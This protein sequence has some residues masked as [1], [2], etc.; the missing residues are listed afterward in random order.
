MVQGPATLGGVYS[1]PMAMVRFLELLLLVARSP[2]KGGFDRF[3]LPIAG[4][5]QL[6]LP[7]GAVARLD[8][9]GVVNLFDFGPKSESYGKVEVSRAS[10]AMAQEATLTVTLD[11]SRDPLEYAALVAVPTTVA[12]KQTEDILSDYKG[13]LIYGQQAMGTQKMQLISVPFRGSRSLR[14]LLE[15]AF[16]GTSPGAVVIRHLENQGDRGALRIPEIEVK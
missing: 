10:L 3:G 5:A 13:Q 16:A 8:K 11:A 12:I 6:E 4:P 14:L 1:T 9:K 15:G 7:E 2:A